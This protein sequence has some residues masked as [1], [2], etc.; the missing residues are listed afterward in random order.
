MRFDREI[1]F[2]NVRATLFDGSLNQEQV[3]GLEMV[4]GAWERYRFDQDMRFLSYELATDF[5]ETAATMQPIEE[6]G[7]GEGHTYGNVDPETG[8]AYYGRGL[9]QLTWRENYARADHEILSLF[10]IDVGMEWDADKALNPRVATGVMFLGM[11]QGWFTGRKLSDYFNDEKDDP[12]NARQII[13]GN[14]R[15]ELIA[16]YHADFLAALSLSQTSEPVP[17]PV[18]KRE[19]VTIEGTDIVIMVNGER[20][21]A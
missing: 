15:D 11:E 9:V 2:D 1:F 13:N 4:L 5:H 14:D 20:H 16:G 18:G 12:V 6:Y 17:A 19:T 7:K 10:A 3:D 8:Q 21:P